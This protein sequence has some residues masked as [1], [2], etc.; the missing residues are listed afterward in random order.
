ML[1]FLGNNNSKNCI[2]NFCIYA[3]SSPTSSI[4]VQF[5]N[6]LSNSVRRSGGSFVALIVELHEFFVYVEKG[7]DV[8]E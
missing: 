8:I 2:K 6:S 5:K 1:K 4:F 7:V 3:K